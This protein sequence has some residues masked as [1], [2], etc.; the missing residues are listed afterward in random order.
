M[1]YDVRDFGAKGDGET[2]NS[3]AIQK[4]VDKCHLDGGGRVLITDGIYKSGAFV[5]K[6]N[7][8]LFIDKGAVLLGS[9]NVEDYPEHTDMAHAV[10]YKLPR[11]SS[12]CFIF[13][14][15]CENIGIAGEGTIDCNGEKFVE[16]CGKL[17][18][19][20]RRKSL[21]TPPRVVFFVGCK[22]VTVKDVTMVNQPAGW[23]YWLHDCDDASFERLVIRSNLEYPNNDGI[24][25]NCSRNVSVTDCDIRCGD[26]CIAV[27]ANSVSLLRCKPC[28]NVRVDNCRFTSYSAGVRL[29]WM[30]DGV[31]RNCRFTN[32]VMTDTTVGVSIMFPYIDPE[33]SNDFGIENTLIEDIEF[34]GIKMEK[35]CSNPIKICLSDDERIKVRAVR[36][37]TFR[38]IEA[39]GIEYPMLIGTPKSKL[40][41]ISFIKCRFAMQPRESVPNRFYHGAC[42]NWDDLYHPMEIRN[43]ENLVLND[44]CLNLL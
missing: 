38:D 19:P 34:S 1:V 7:V 8:E 14:D 20:Y 31:I 4:A 3:L 5:L 6:S 24:H 18:W 43:V 41:N 27:R 39:S 29:G 40:R 42:T 44:V 11:K 21:K 2:V 28:E 12:S 30:N 26:D 9:E 35:M 23:G 33:Q 15:E 13:A 37:I 16:Y 22:N 17:G 32:I 25:I 10:W 36:D